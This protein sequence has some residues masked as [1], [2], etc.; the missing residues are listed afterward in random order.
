MPV[1]CG[2]HSWLQ[3]G[4]TYNFKI[5]KIW[6]GV[7]WDLPWILPNAKRKLAGAGWGVERKR[8]ENGESLGLRPH[9]LTSGIPPCGIKPLCPW[10]YFI[11]GDFYVQEIFGKHSCKFGL[12]WG[13]ETPACS[14]IQLKDMR[15]SLPLMSGPGLLS[16]LDG[17]CQH[18]LCSC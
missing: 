9:L 6:D 10:I 5:A 17:S 8:K 1:V 4:L 16:R 18:T 14:P 7:W 2:S 3:N 13:E 12:L 15:A 11:K